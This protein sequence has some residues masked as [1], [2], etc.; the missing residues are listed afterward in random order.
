MMKVVDNKSYRVSG[1]REDDIFP[2]T[3]FYESVDQFTKGTNVNNIIDIFLGDTDSGYVV[4]VE[5]EN[6]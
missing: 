1:F 4:V 3:P 6:E 2:N 5:V